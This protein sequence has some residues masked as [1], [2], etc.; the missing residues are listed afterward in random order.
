MVRRRWPSRAVRTST[1]TE[2]RANLAPAIE[3]GALC[4]DVPLRGIPPRF[5]QQAWRTDPPQLRCQHARRHHD[6]ESANLFSA[7]GLA[8]C[9][10]LLGPEL[11]PS[12]LV[13]RAFR[14]IH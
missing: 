6:R 3:A 7:D 11:E 1:P 2:S 5:R 4:N 10:V 8:K 9:H 13:R 14:A 12:Y